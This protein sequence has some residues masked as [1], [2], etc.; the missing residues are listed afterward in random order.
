MSLEIAY[1]DIEAL[2]VHLLSELNANNLNNAHV[3]DIEETTDVRRLFY[4]YRTGDKNCDLR[5]TKLGQHHP[6]TQSHILP[7]AVGNLTGAIRVVAEVVRS[8]QYN[9]VVS[10]VLVLFELLDNSR[11]FGRQGVEN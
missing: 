10:F 2:L 7:R 4:P 6:H 1:I 11:T 5:S 8:D 3:W 9:S